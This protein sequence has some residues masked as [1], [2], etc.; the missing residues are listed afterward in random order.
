MSTS[1]NTLAREPKM[2][3]KI[4][5]DMMMVADRDGGFEWSAMELT[6]G[7]VDRNSRLARLLIQ[8]CRAV[9]LDS[10]ESIRANLRI[11]T[12]QAG[13]DIQLSPPTVRRLPG[14]QSYGA[15]LH[16]PPRPPRAEPLDATT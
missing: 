10:L 3:T 4:V 9:Q 15:R 13:S 12:W 7:P 1:A 5:S 2:M 11:V 6:A 14:P 8:L 16:R